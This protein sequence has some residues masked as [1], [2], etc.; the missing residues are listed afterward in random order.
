MPNEQVHLH[1]WETK[2]PKESTPYSPRYLDVIKNNNGKE[3]R[4]KRWLLD[5][6]KRL[7]RIWRK[8]KLHTTKDI[9]HEKDEKDKIRQSLQ[10]Y[11]WVALPDG[12]VFD[13]QALED[14]EA[15]ERILDRIYREKIYIADLHTGWDAGV[16]WIWYVLTSQRNKR[17]DRD[18]IQSWLEQYQLHNLT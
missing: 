7:N 2:K 18:S 16:S 12:S 8:E 17:K 10:L 15:I 9:A 13:P 5:I 6:L 11:S 3:Q 1:H 14:Q 4:E